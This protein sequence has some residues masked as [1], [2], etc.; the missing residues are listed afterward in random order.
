MSNIDLL[1]KLAYE[2]APFFFAVLYAVV[3]PPIAYRWYSAANGRRPANQLEQ[4]TTRQWFL[5]TTYFGF[6]LVVAAIAWYI[7]THRPSSTYMYEGVVVDVKVNEAV[8]SAD[9]FS[10]PEIIG[11]LTELRNVRFVIKRDRPFR[12]GEKLLL[13]F[14]EQPTTGGVDPAAKPLPQEIW[15]EIAEPIDVPQRFKVQRQP[16]GKL[17]AER[18]PA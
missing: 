16:T 14:Y 11:S 15:I 17:V 6:G 10:R 5:T 13:Y 9:F 2:F 4:K 8:E 1:T 3:I 7:F 18:I 12:V